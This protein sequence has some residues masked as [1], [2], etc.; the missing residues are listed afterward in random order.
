MID[1]ENRGSR[2]QRRRQPRR[3][4]PARLRY[5]PRQRRPD[6]RHAATFNRQELV[7]FGD[8]L[9][10]RAVTLARIRVDEGDDQ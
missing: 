9:G 2:R 8:D 10:A 7:K 6:H 3:E 1:A 4:A 5:R